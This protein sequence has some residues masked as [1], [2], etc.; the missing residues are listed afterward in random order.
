MISIRMRT[1]PVILGAFAVFSSHHAS[2]QQA[3]PFQRGVKIEVTTSKPSDIKGGD[4][5]DKMQKI[6]V[7][8]K[9][10]NI[11]TRQSYANY[12]AT[13]SAFGQSTVDRTV[14]KVLMQESFPVTLAPRRLI[15]HE[16]KP[17][18][19]QFDK[20]GAKFG[21]FYDGWILVVKDASGN[22]I[23]VKSTSP[24]LE[25]LTDKVDKLEK[26]K[27]YDRSLSLVDDPDYRDRRSS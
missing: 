11:D 8:L 24:S 4:F 16:C 23:L 26:D 18:S 10:T 13:V 15:E 5:D 3:L 27:C 14:S 9:F 20:T 1:L 17:V 19:T 2:A 25:K 21:Y 22:I 6:V 12:T 7:R